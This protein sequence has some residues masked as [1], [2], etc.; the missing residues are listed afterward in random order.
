MMHMLVEVQ[1]KYEALCLSYKPVSKIDLVYSNALDVS[2]L[3]KFKL[4]SLKV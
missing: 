3:S 2:L 4:R 1:N